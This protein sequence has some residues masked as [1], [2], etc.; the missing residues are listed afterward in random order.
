MAGARGPR[1]RDEDDPN[2][3]RE[4]RL[5]L[6]NDI[7]QPS[8][9]PVAH[10]G[11]PEAFGGD[12]SDTKGFLF[13]LDEYPQDK[14]RSSKGFPLEFDR[15]EFFRP[16]QPFRLRKGLIGRFRRSH[17]INHNTAPR[18]ASLEPASLLLEPARPRAAGG[19]RSH[20]FPQRPGG[21]PSPLAPWS[22]FACRHARLKSSPCPPTD[23]LRIFPP[24]EI[25]QSS[26]SRLPRIG[27]NRSCLRQNA[28][29]SYAKFGSVR[30]RS[31]VGGLVITFSC[32]ITSTFSRDLKSM[33]SRSPDGFRPGKEL[34]LEELP[35]R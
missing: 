18:G 30:R 23:I 19:R 27:G 32:Q 31:M 16:R 29:Q 7:S 21:R 6:S 12:K 2:A 25:T 24:I 28:T 1:P 5:F 13:F 14:Q 11:S 26:S 22:P 10:H 4:A 34:A 20:S 3:L 15:R 8:A 33:A 9:H 35:K 17:V